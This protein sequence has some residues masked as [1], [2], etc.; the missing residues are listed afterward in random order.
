MIGLLA[1]GP[2]GFAAG[3]GTTIAAFAFAL[4][5]LLFAPETKGRLLR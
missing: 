3:L 4:V 1:S 5:V 2:G